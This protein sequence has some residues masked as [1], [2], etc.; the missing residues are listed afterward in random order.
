M[1]FKASEGGKKERPP[2]DYGTIYL[3]AMMRVVE[4]R[5]LDP[6]YKD[7]TKKMV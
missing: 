3:R 2:M 7:Y 6:D 1:M 4:A 5:I